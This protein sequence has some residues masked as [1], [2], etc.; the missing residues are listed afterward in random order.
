MTCVHEHQWPA[1]GT[2]ARVTIVGGDERLLGTALH[3]VEE[4]EARWSRFREDSELSRLNS[5]E[6]AP[7]VV[8]LDTFTLVEHLVAAWQR[9]AGRFDPTL[10]DALHAIGYMRSWPFAAAGNTMPLQG[11]LPPGCAGVVLDRSTRMVW[12][13]AGL[14]LDPGGLGKGLAADL[15]AEALT[16]QGAHGAL[17]DLGGDLRAIGCSPTGGAWRVA[18]EHPVEHDRTIAVVETTGGGIA[19]SSRGKRRWHTAAGAEVH[20]LL[21]PRTAHPAARPWMSV[22]TLAATAV[23]AEVAATVAFLDGSLACAPW[24]HAALLATADGA[25]QVL[26][27][28]ALFAMSA[29]SH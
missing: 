27:D 4:L 9:T 2:T 16:A 22:T 21:D 18:V 6:G 24:A 10:Y 19:T 3:R 12:L 8:S 23:D 28:A 5:A 25:D 14:R 26:G 13:P 7:C 11:E 29:L 17:V 1:M 15:V 20:H